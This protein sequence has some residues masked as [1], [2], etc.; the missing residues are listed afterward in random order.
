LPAGQLLPALLGTQ[1]TPQN[2]AWASLY[3][4]AGQLLPALL[5]T[6]KTHHFVLLGLRTWDDCS[7]EIHEDGYEDAQ[8]DSIYWEL[9]RACVWVC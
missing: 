8:L 3:L 6:Q 2:P 4:L 5:G 7:R 9:A 1:K